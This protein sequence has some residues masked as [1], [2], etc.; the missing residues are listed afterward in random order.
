MALY[1]IY[2]CKIYN[3]FGSKVV[4]DSNTIYLILRAK[5]PSTMY[6]YV[7]IYNKGQT[8]WEGGGVYGVNKL[9][10]FFN[11]FFYFLLTNFKKWFK[12]GLFYLWEIFHILQTGKYKTELLVQKFNQKELSL[13]Y[14]VVF[15]RCLWLEQRSP[16]A[17]TH[18]WL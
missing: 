12:I 11:F 16:T 17:H 2:Y 3:K 7:H 1:N 5:S 10:I 4:V 6:L 18:Y 13:I 8:Q 14:A 9:Y 15:S